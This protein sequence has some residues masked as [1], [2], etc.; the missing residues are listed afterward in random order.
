MARASVKKTTAKKKP[1]RRGRPPKKTTA[2]KR[3]TAARKKTTAKKKTVSAT[4]QL[5]QA[6][7]DARAK[8]KAVKDELTKVKADLKAAQK[9]EAAL[10]KMID[11]K[12]KAVSSFATKW[13]AKAMKSL[14]KPTIRRRRRK[15]TV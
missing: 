9:R 8:V 15:K 7:A 11:A 3:T 5:R 12:E 4:V 13:Q 2:K 10:M 1:A 14:S 6:R